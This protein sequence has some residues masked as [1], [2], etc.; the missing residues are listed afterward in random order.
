M[1]T[2]TQ[3][4]TVTLADGRT[5][6]SDSP[7]WQA[8]CL[9]QHRHVQTLLRMRSIVERRQYLDGVARSEGSESADR[10]RRAFTTAWH[11]RKEEGAK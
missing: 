4:R 7:E 5:V 9:T 8:E 2:T 10:L 1:T 6:P 11:E 3:P